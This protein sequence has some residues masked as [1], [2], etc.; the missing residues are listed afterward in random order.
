M[1][2]IVDVVG[3]S[4]SYGPIL[5]V[6]DLSFSVEEG[7]V[8]GLL[9][10]NGAGKTT[11][12]SIIIGLLRPD[13]GTAIVAG[14]DIRKQRAAAQRI[15]GYAP[16]DT[17]L[18]LILTGRENLEY[19]ADLMRVPVRRRSERLDYVIE[20]FDLRPLL[21]R[22]VA[23]LSAGERRKLHIATAI[24]HVPRVLILDE[25]T[26]FLDV[27]TRRALLDTLRSIASEGTTV[28]YS[29]HALQE[30]EQ[31]C[32]ECLILYRGRCLEKGSISEIVS[33][34]GRPAIILSIEGS[35]D[36]INVE[37][38]EMTVRD[39]RIVIRSDEEVEPGMLLIRAIEALRPV[40]AN[41]SGVNVVQ[42]SLEAAFL[43]LIGMEATDIVK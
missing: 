22:R 33:R 23:T 17:G 4:K 34:H 13:T 8:F 28:L 27:P 30:V 12:A 21:D 15:M 16:Q 42:P 36:P 32:S 11:T 7:T 24:I 41:I 10:P 37:G 19:F 3:L 38:L 18:H 1:S 29:T 31:I 25:P 43:T 20:A 26:A 14:L 40:A 6:D 9:G 35:V 2:S 39:D 5:A